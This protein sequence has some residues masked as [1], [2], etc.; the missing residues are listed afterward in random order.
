M[1]NCSL[2]YVGYARYYDGG[3]L[4]ILEH[5]EDK[6]DM[7]KVIQ[8]KFKACVG[9]SKLYIRFSPIHYINH[10]QIGKL[11]NPLKDTLESL[12]WNAHSYE[13][14]QSMIVYRITFHQ[15]FSCTREMKK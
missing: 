7:M 9:H 4:Q 11:V 10:I 12:T 1:I 6:N 14:H 2:E 13:V 5:E 8:I 3:L 15:L